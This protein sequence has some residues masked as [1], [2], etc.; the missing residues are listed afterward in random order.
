MDQ[1]SEKTGDPL[2][3]PTTVLKDHDSRLSLVVDKDQMMIARI[4]L[5]PIKETVQ[6]LVILPTSCK[7]VKVLQ[8]AWFKD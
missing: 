7:V 8:N 1:G 2:R 5:S 4:L 6:L 3:V